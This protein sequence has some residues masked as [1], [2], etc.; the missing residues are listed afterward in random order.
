MYFHASIDAKGDWLDSI[1][2]PQAANHYPV[3]G[4]GF[5]GMKGK[6]VEEFGVY[7]AR[8]KLLQEDWY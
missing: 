4:K 1:F 2:F 7:S 5:Y 3:T 6:V 8:S